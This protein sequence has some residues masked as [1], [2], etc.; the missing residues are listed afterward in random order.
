MAAIEINLPIQPNDEVWVFWQSGIYKC[1]VLS[2][3]TNIEPPLTFITTAKLELLEPSITFRQIRI[4]LSDIFLT[5]QSLLDYL[6]GAIPT[7]NLVYTFT[8]TNKTPVLIDDI[9]AGD[10]TFIA[11]GNPLVVPFN[12]PNYLYN[13]LAIPKTMPIPNNYKNLLNQD[14]DG[15][16]GQDGDLWEAPYEVGDYNVFITNWETPVEDTYLFTV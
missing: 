7:D 2:L 3:I 10:S 15:T 4:P 6:N 12:N 8:K 9:L 14:D 1:K 13:V 11:A 16:I 5:K